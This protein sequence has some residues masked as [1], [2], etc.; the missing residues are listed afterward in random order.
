MDGLIGASSER[1]GWKPALQKTASPLD[2]GICSAGILPA[3]LGTEW[4]GEYSSEFLAQSGKKGRAEG[5][6]GGG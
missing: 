2:A 4:S 6:G 3:W 1:A 5:D